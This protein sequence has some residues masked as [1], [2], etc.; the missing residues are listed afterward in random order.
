MAP[1][2][3]ASPR[4]GRSADRL[5]ARDSRDSTPTRYLGTFKLQ[6]LS[7][8]DHLLPYTTKSGTREQGTRPAQP[9][10]HAAATTMRKASVFAEIFASLT[11]APT[12]L[13]WRMLV[14]RWGLIPHEWFRPRLYFQP[15]FSGVWL[16][17]FPS[18]SRSL[19][20]HART[21]D[22]SSSRVSS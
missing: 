16:S 21:D 19:Y 20:S 12:L 1:R 13:C 8:W 6:E 2:R 17:A 9:R 22:C 7:H 10:G 3:G 5:P 15:L 4:R 14:A 11:T 18:P